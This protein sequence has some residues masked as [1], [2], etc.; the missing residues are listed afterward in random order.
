MWY[1]ALTLPALTAGWLLG[2]SVWGM[3]PLRCALF[4]AFSSHHL[5]LHVLRAV[6]NKDH[7]IQDSLA[8]LCC[9]P[10]AVV[11]GCTRF[12]CTACSWLPPRHIHKFAILHLWWGSSPPL[13]SQKCLW[14]V[15]RVA[16]SFLAAT[17]LW[18]RWPWRHSHSRPSSWRTLPQTHVLDPSPSAVVPQN[19]GPRTDGTSSTHAWTAWNPT[20]QDIDGR[21]PSVSRLRLDTSF[22]DLDRGRTLHPPQ[23]CALLQRCG[24]WL[25]ALPAWVAALLHKYAAPEVILGVLPSRLLASPLPSA[26]LCRTRALLGALGCCVTFEWASCLLGSSPLRG[27]CS[28]SSSAPSM[29]R[30]APSAL[31]G[32]PAW[33]TALSKASSISSASSSS[34]AHMLLHCAE[35]STAP[36]TIAWHNPLGYCCALLARPPMRCW[37][38]WLPSHFWLSLLARLSPLTKKSVGFLFRP[39]CT[40]SPYT[41]WCPRTLWTPFMAAAF[42]THSSFHPRDVAGCSKIASL[43][44]ATCHR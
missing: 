43:P 29:S 3:P 7:Q 12:C 44:L 28:S 36:C 8:V 30:G 32:S 13:A 31:T 23:L 18:H 15:L 9:I 25:R 17:V 20:A 11:L 10:T 24:E 35:S 41:H 37:C 33:S 34:V 40:W 22:L 19:F 4:A 38:R 1:W 27:S 5:L 2:R 14:L 42:S 21:F 16:R 39:S 26:V 6:G